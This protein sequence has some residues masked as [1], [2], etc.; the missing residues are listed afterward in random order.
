MDI[1][2]NVE[3]AT[4]DALVHEAGEYRDHGVTIADIVA[5]KL[6]KRITSDGERWPAFRDKVTEIRDDEI[7]K[8]LAP[9]IAD[10][11]SR[12]F[13]VTNTYGEPV[14]KETT[15]SELITEEARKQL[16]SSTGDS[17]SRDRRSIVQQMIA[18]E[19]QQAF[20]EVVAAEVK[21]ARELV[22]D[23][24]G[25]QVAAAVKAGLAKR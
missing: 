15:L 11:V 3:G 19:V 8:V 9:L 2:V 10:A 21:K 7:R 18:K 20:A 5:D 4:L 1:T 6:V 23:E 12:P 24:I 25:Q 17:Y 22:A 16:N 14:G 13:K